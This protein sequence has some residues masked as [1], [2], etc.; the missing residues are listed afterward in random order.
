VPSSFFIKDGDKMADADVRLLIGVARG[1]ADG[2]SEALIRSEINAIMKN[3]KAEVKLDTANFRTQL[4]K[5]LNAVGKSGKF[6]INLSR[7]NIGAGAIADFKNQLS[8]VI[9]TLNLDKGTSVTITAEG[10]GEIKSQMSEAGNAATNAAQKVAEFRVQIEALSRQKAT[11]NK[12]LIGLD[13]SAQTEDERAKVAELITQYEQWAVKIEAV[14]ASK[15]AV[16]GEY[17]SELEAEGAAILANIEKIQQEKAAAESTAATQKAAAESRRAAEELASSEAENATAAETKRQS[18]LRTSVTLLKQMQDAEAKWTA[19]KNGKSSANYAAIQGYIQ[20]LRE[21][22]AQFKNGEISMEAFSAKVQSMRTDFSTASQGIREVG[23]NTQTLMARMGGLAQKFS[24]WF[25]ITRV[26]MAIVRAIKQM[27]TAV[28]EID[29]A[30]TQLKIVTGATDS[31]MSQFLTKS[32]S[33]AKELGQSITD[34]LGSIE[35]FSR[36]G[37]NLE[38]ASTLAEYTAI[39]SNVAAVDTEEATTGMTSIIKGYN[40]KVE[41]AEHVADVLVQVGQKYAVSAG[42]MMEA[43]EK[44]SAAL[45]ATNTSFE[46]SA[47]LIAAANASVQDASTVGTALKTV[48]A[49][50]RGAK[51][52]LEELGEDTNGLAQGF[53]KYAEEIKALTGFDIMVEGTTDTYKDIYDIFEGIAQVWDKLSDTQQARVAEIL[54]GTRQL[55]VISSIIGNWGDAAG[56][57]ADAMDAA[58]VATQ[59]NATYMDSVAGH[60]Q[61]LKTTFQEFS[62]NLVNGDLIKGIVDIGTS[63]LSVLNNVVKL[64]DTFGGLKTVLLAIGSIAVVKNSKAIAGSI[65]GLI[66]FVSNLIPKCKDLKAAID[67]VRESGG[68][69]NS[70]LSLAEIP[71]TSLQIGI[72]ATVAAIVALVAMVDWLTESFDEAVKKAQ[73]SQQ[74]YEEQKSKVDDLNKE[75]ETTQQRIDELSAKG[76][77]S[78]VEQEELNNLRTTNDLLKEQLEIE[79]AIA[80]YRGAEAAADANNVLTKRSFGGGGTNPRPRRGGQGGIGTNNKPVDIIDDT[81]KKQHEANE[82]EKERNALIEGRAKLLKENGDDLDDKQ[83]KSYE[84][85][86]DSL[87]KKIVKAQSEIAENWSIIETTQSSLYDSS[88]NIIKGYEETAGRIKELGTLIADSNNDISEETLAKQKQID[89]F[90]SRPTLS[91]YVADVTAKA[92]ELNGISIDNFEAQFPELAQA[93][94]SAGLEITDVVNSINSAAGTVDYDEF[95]SQLQKALIPDDKQDTIMGNKIKDWIHSLSDE[96]IRIVYGIYASNDTDAW[97]FED[98]QFELDEAKKRAKGEISIW[99]EP[100]GFEAIKAAV[101]SVS[102]AQTTFSS[103]LMDGNSI[104]EEAYEGLVALAGSEEALA[105]CI[106]VT[107]GYLVTN[108][109]E[110]NNLIGKVTDAAKAELKLAESQD[111]L[112]HHEMVN[113]LKQL[114]SGEKEYS[115]ETLAVIDAT[116]QQIDATELEIAQYKLLEQQLLGVTNAFDELERAKTI[117][118]ARDYTDELSESISGLIKAFENHEFGTEYFKTAFKSLIPEDVYSQFTE[119]G[120]QLD[121]GWEYLNTKLAKYFTFDSGNVSI[122]FGNIQSLVADGLATAFNDSTVFT[123]TLGNFDLNPQ[124][125][126]LT[127]FADAMGITETAAFSL[128]NAISKYT[129]DSDDFLSKLSMDG[130]SLET[131]ILACDTEMASLLKTQTELGKAGKISGPEW[132]EL[133]NK[134][135]AANQ[136]MNELQKKAKGDIKK[137]IELESNIPEQQALVD[138]LEE[139]LS[140]LTEEDDEYQVTWENYQEE[141]A[142]LDEML[143]EKYQ[144]GEPTSLTVEVALEEIDNEITET[145]KRL[146]EIADFDGQ[147]YIAKVGANPEEVRSLAAELEQLEQDK[148]EIQ[149]YAG[150]EDEATDPLEKIEEFQIG[151]KKFSVIANTSAAR[152]TVDSFARYLDASLKDKTVNVTV[153][154]TQKTSG[155]S[156]GKKAGG[157]IGPTQAAVYQGTAH[158]Q[159]VWGTRTPERNSLVGELGR[160]IYVD[161]RTGEWKTVGDNGAELVNLPKGAIIFNHRQTEEL[162]KNRRINSR[163]KAYAEGNAHFTFI[164]G[165]YSFGTPNRTP[166]SSGGNSSAANVTVSATLDNKSLEEQLE[167]TLKKMADEIA[168]IIGNFEHSIFLLEKNGGRPADIIAIYRKMQ[169]AVHAQAEEYRKLGLDENSDYIQ[170]LQKQWWEYQDSIQDVIISDYEKSAKERE[171]AITLTENWLEKAISERNVVDVERYAGDIAAY[172]RQMQEIIH[173]QAEYYR[174][175]GYSDTSD[176]VSKLSDLWWDYEENIR[177]VKQR[178]V[179]NLVDMVNAA[180]DAVDEIQDVFDTLKSVADEYAENGG[181]ISVDAFQKIVDLGPE[182]MQYLRDENGL[183]VI[184]EENIN[185]VIAAKTEQLALE[186]AMSYV[187]RLRLALQSESLEDLNQLLYATTETANSTWGLVYANLALLGLSSDQYDAA[188]H[189]INAIRSIADTA[190]AGIGKTTDSLSSMQEGLDDILKYVMDMLKQKIEDQIDA[191]E[192]M[193][194]SYADIIEL[195]KESLK[196]AKEEAGYGDEV[197]EKVKQIAK[198]QERINALSLDDSRSAQAQKAKLEEEMVELQKELADSQS[199]Y[200]INA[201]ED[202]LDKMQEAYEEEKDAEILALERTISSYQKLYDMAIDYI[203]THWDTLYSELIAWN[204]EYGS[205]LNSEITTAWDNCLAAAQRYGSYVAA[206]NAVGSESVGGTGGSGNNV[207][208]GNKTDNSSPTAEEMLH[209]TI[210]K[211]YRNSISWAT[212][213]DKTR[214][215]R[216]AENLRLGASLSQFG[217]SAVRGSDGVWYIDNIGG[218]K[219]YDRYRKYCYH[220]GGIAGDMPTLK[221]NEVLA[222]LEKGEPVLDKKKEE[223]LYRIVDFVTTLSE[224]LGKAIDRASMSGSLV[225]AQ[226]GLPSLDSS[227]PDSIVNSRTDSIHFGDVYIYG[228]NAETIE[229]HR[230]INRQFTNDV[231]RQLNIKR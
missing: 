69:L 117:D 77:L 196:A 88:G 189:N 134:I 44:S 8:A 86:I 145:K 76:S 166:S 32:I 154:T 214:A 142:K 26:I 64:I 190:I 181:F 219:L 139:K 159:G 127:Q 110:L 151:D 31:Q 150:I 223:G 37:Y 218:E 104:T 15:T 199:D 224:K 146:N 131:Q 41:E 59:A 119:A 161:P 27:V 186:S 205:V 51:T 185:K 34:V 153:N 63:I 84:K 17:R 216:D 211:M 158:E 28:V 82:L 36:L 129:A 4:R 95:K 144:L 30:L 128:A 225:N 55:Q 50:I 220:K 228:A 123:G 227:V 62:Q 152:K 173:E 138:E 72:T 20:Q 11:V 9:N 24:A 170:D 135:D 10:I 213:D 147:T 198:L 3:I 108:A 148:H 6:S 57:Y 22:I 193:K 212:A 13:N 155:G 184:N 101:D 171:N 200:A 118:N 53:S 99:A 217:V 7:I 47:G 92:K 67:L 143:R 167:D 90:L 182:Y 49:R 68:G 113:V 80:N 183:L 124:I 121:A 70:V 137:Y 230:K 187:E 96:D 46:K 202:A 125:T 45:N 140:H 115:S 14:R 204:T 1:G 210:R 83:V 97:T 78:L 5:E 168:E 48:S 61:V 16:T 175:Q 177:E 172:Y 203:Q 105:G 33:L 109:D 126:S 58:G 180:S 201:Q 157:G 29:S 176:E 103:V 94:R 178:V 25:S 179:D 12:A 75:L 215:E 197:A 91:K 141:K 191:L 65:N 73:E 56:A 133:Q 226:S 112:K 195:R 54:G 164:N 42:E 40:L 21:L 207:V 221:Q 136:K 38:D 111:I 114:C 60:I 169:E 79:Q 66:G 35:T 222:V 116:L 43:Y 174:S 102:T 192:D 98:W 149:V 2:D 23:E 122:D 52:E 130:A 206:L 229:E 39:L 18:A 209:A 100:K 107:N 160:E 19:A 87:E 81:I 194:D 71:L 156:S 231:L 165:N 85:Q 106:D 120:D 93:A 188:L 208:V 132:D 162:L 74:A 163:G 89:D